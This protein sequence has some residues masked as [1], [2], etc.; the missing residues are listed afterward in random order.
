[1]KIIQ[2]KCPGCGAK[3]NVSDQ[4][5]SFTCNFCGIT[6]LLDDE[7]IRVEHTIKNAEE[8]E[9]YKKID[10]YIKLDYYDDAEDTVDELIE[11]RAYDPRTW[12]YAIKVYTNNYDDNTVCDLDMINDFFDNY[13]KLEENDNVLEKNTSIIEKY[14]K[15]KTDAI[16]DSI[17][18]E[19]MLCPYCGEKIRFGQRKCES[20]DKDLDWPS[21]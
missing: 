21:Y 16:I 8:D 2:L 7:V 14:I 9:L 11:K 4:L 10:G 17:N 20:C 12:L 3:L 6:S 15:N 1:M 5:K 18:E 19:S 13:K